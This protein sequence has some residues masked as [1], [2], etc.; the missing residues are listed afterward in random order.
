MAG[1]SGISAPRSVCIVLYIYLCFTNYSSQKSKQHQIQ[2]SYTSSILDLQL[3]NTKLQ[4]DEIEW[5]CFKL[6]ASSPR[7]PANAQCPPLAT[8]RSTG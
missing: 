5:T 6:S 8:T 2:A 7:L 3:S 1:G 4:C